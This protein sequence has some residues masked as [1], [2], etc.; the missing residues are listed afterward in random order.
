MAG[1]WLCRALVDRRGVA[2][3]VHEDMLVSS[4]PRP[5]VVLGMISAPEY[6]ERRLG[7]RHSWLQW[8]NVKS[9]H[10]GASFVVR[11]GNAPQWL[12]QL[13]AAEQERYNDVLRAPTVAWNETRLRGPVL[14]LAVWLQYAVVHH[15]TARFIGKLDDDAFLHAGDFERLLSTVAVSPFSTYM[16]MGS[17][18]WYA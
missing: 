11:S 13:L 14:S 4:A 18:T 10:I 17:M 1:C 8:A 15:S 3:A 16:Y 2:A 9:G 5:L 6:L 12:D 7:I